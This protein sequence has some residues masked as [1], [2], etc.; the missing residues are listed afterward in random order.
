MHLGNIVGNPRLSLKYGVEADRTKWEAT[1][2]NWNLE[3]TTFLHPD[4]GHKV[5]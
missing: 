1:K 4:D 5:E 2:E 3:T